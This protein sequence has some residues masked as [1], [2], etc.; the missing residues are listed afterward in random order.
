[1]GPKI[2]LSVSK[3]KGCCF[4]ITMSYVKVKG[5]KK[6]RA[7]ILALGNVVV[8]CGLDGV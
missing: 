5:P 6:K 4:N 3:H 2:E 7:N 1:M 8:I